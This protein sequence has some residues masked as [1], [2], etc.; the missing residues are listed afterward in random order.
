MN[1]DASPPP[2]PPTSTLKDRRSRIVLLVA[3]AILALGMLSLRMSGAIRPCAVPTGAMSPAV[4]PGDQIIVERLTFWSRK[5]VRGDIVAFDTAAVPEIPSPPSLWIKRVAG[6][7]GDQL[8]IA[9]GKLYIN[10]TNAMLGNAEGEIHYVNY[11]GSIYLRS[12]ND[13]LT[14]SN[15]CYFVLGDNSSNSSDSRFWGLLPAKSV[16]GRATY[17]YWPPARMGTI[18]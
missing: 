7:P 4:S 14:V 15:D 1:T 17:C 3:A 6:L 9:D 16:I 5:P 10:G 2:P 18:K 8:R 11:P 12:T 13:T